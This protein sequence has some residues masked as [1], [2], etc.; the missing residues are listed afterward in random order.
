MIEKAKAC[1]SSEE[2]LELAKSE[3]IELND[4]QIDAIAGGKHGHGEGDWS[5]LA[6]KI[7]EM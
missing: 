7:K 3:G 1:Q 2:L 6:R 4:E 5:D